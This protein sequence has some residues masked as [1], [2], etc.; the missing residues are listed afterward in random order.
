MRHRLAREDLGPAHM[1]PGHPEGRWGPSHPIQLLPTLCN[2]K[3]E[4][5]GI[6]STQTLPVSSHQVTGTA[7]SW[8]E[9]MGTR[10]CR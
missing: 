4:E 6:P 9:P 3:R 5:G 8:P 1:E 2:Q 10:L 7:A